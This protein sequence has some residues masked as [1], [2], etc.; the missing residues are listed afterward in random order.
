MADG[1]SV[2][3]IPKVQNLK[4]SDKKNRVGNL[5]IFIFNKLNK[6]IAR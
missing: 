1:T 3:N 4:N 2:C 6:S 5:L